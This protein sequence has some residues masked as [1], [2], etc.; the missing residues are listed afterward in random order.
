MVFHDVSFIDLRRTVKKYRMV[1]VPLNPSTICSD[2]ILY[3]KAWWKMLISHY[4]FVIFNQV[5]ENIPNDLFSPNLRESWD[6]EDSG[7]QVH[8]HDSGV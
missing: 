1:K 6:T 7:F 3:S 8:D 5:C 2:V 4:L